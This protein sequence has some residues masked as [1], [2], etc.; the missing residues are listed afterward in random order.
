MSRRT[1]YTLFGL[2]FVLGLVGLISETT[3]IIMATVLMGILVGVIADRFDNLRDEPFKPYNV[4]HGH[5]HHK[6]E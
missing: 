2:I 3:V 5:L 6:H 4:K 1:R